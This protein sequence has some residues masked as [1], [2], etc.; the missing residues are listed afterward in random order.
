MMLLADES[1]DRQIVNQLRK[2]VHTVLY[3]VA[4][5]PGISDVTVLPLDNWK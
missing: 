4:M 5:D 3:A 1:I 2:D